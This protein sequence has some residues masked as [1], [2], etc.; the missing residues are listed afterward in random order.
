[1]LIHINLKRIKC[2]G[3]YKCPR[4]PS[5][6]DVK[7]CVFKHW[8]IRRLLI[9]SSYFIYSPCIMI[10]KILIWAKLWCCLFWMY[11]Q[12]AIFKDQPWQNQRFWCNNVL[13]LF[14]IAI[15]IVQCI[16]LYEQY[17]CYVFS[18]KIRVENIN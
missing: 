7:Q 16:I 4:A 9:S 10:H 14:A 13:L 8:G 1:M 5:Q 15:H 2:C 18:K 11:P 6:C 17:L 12:D 3:M